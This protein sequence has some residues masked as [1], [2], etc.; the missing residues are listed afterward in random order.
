MS[1][2]LKWTFITVLILAVMPWPAQ[3]QVSRTGSLAGRVIDTEG[4]PLPGVNVTINSKAL[5]GGNVTVQTNKDGLYRFLSLPPGLY[6]VKF[7]MPGFQTALNESVRVSLSAATNL[8]VTLTSGI[9]EEVSVVA[10]KPVVDVKE[11]SLTTN[12]SL[13]FLQDIPVTREVLDFIEMTPGYHDETAHGSSDQENS[14]N[15]D[16]MESSD[17]WSGGIGSN[18]SIDIVEEIAVQMGGLKAENRTSRGAVVNIHTKSGGNKLSGSI[19]THIADKSLQSD[20]SAGTPFEG[21]KV[22]IDHEY[23]ASGTLGLPIVRDKAWFF[24]AFEYIGRSDFEAGFPFDN[25]SKIA[26]KDNDLF[27]FSKLTWQVAPQ[28]RL[29]L[30]LNYRRND[31]PYAG[32]SDTRNLD[33]TSTDDDTNFVGSLNYRKTFGSKILIDTQVGYLAQTQEQI[34]NGRSPTYQDRDTGFYTRG[35]GRDR[36]DN[37]YR[38]NIFSD[39]T[40]LIDDWIG[41]HEIKAGVSAD[42]VKTDRYDTYLEGEH[43]YPG[44]PGKVYRIRTRGDI[45]YDIRF[46]IDFSRKVNFDYYGAYIQ[47]TWNPTPRLVLN[48]GVRLDS[49]YGYLPP[50]GAGREKL[51]LESPPSDFYYDPEFT[52]RIEVVKE[53]NISPRLGAVLDLTG[54]GKTVVKASYGRLYAR[55]LATYIDDINPNDVIEYTYRLNPDYSLDFNRGW[56]DV[57]AGVN[58]RT[59]PNLKTPYMDEITLG[60]ERELV[61]DF[62][63]GLRYI[64]KWD[65]RMMD[66]VAENMLDYDRLMSTGELVWTNFEPVQGIDPVTGDPITFWSQ[67][68]V[69]LVPELTLTNPPGLERNYNGF[70]LTLDKQ[71]SNNWMARVSYV[72][73]KSTG[74]YGLTGSLYPIDVSGDLFNDPNAHTNIL[75]RDESE[76]RH[77]I[78]FNASYRGPW[79]IMGST[80]IRWWSGQRYNR[81]VNSDDVGVELA[82]GDWDVLA[83]P[84]GSYGLPDQLLVDFRLQ[85]AFRIGDVRRI[86]LSADFFNLLNANT[87]TN[88]QELSSNPNIIFGSPRDILFPRQLRFNVMFEF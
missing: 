25:P 39:F 76:R 28:D 55:G 63:L 43:T 6:Q 23:S 65:R 17:P 12:I 56:Y 88:V 22:G 71:F 16:G 72:Y 79:G 15:L 45:P 27:T 10:E 68:D 5:I 44:M 26:L 19:G 82:Q 34:S 41:S 77:Q 50:G 24:G 87:V 67:I 83:E 62:R 30:S 54:D 70:E 2:V 3:A 81:F 1:K 37:E 8:N 53:T 33:S 49:Q 80:F 9:A 85:K 84:R 86:R 38:F 69:N 20:N 4:Q 14:I 13:E 11:V 61:P 52:E 57:R 18:F 21:Q 78:R 66:D 48:L 47:D 40:S 29:T 32:A 73:G 35:D 42:W 7:E 60:I 36:G 59:E 46:R 51:N 58:R 74:N 75:G 31:E 64:R